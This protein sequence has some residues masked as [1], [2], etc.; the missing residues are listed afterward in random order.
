MLSKLSKLSFIG[1]L[2]ASLT[3]AFVSAKVLAEAIEQPNI[4]IFY[5]DDL[6]WQDSQLN[7][8][9]KPTP[10]E[11]PNMLAL[12]QKGMNF[13]QGYSPAPTCAPS[14]AGI[15]SG[16]HP[17]KL[18]LTH[19]LG[20]GIP[21]ASKN[22]QMIAPYFNDHF[23]PDTLTLAQALKGN[24]YKTGHVG[25]W[26]L[27][28]YAD[29]GPLTVGFDYSYGGRGSHRNS[30]YRSKDFAT[31]AAKDK[32]R[33]SDEKYLPFSE[34]HPEGISYPYDLVTEN[35]L[36]F[37]D[38]NK[39]QPFFLYLAHWMVHYP[40]VTKNRN[41]LEYYTDKLGIEFPKDSSNVTTPG[42]TN[43]YYGAMVTTVDWSLGRLVSLLE[44]TDDPRHPGKKLIDTTY[45]FFTSDNGGAEDRGTEIFTD[46]APLDMGKKHAQE[47]GIRVPMVITGPIVNENA[48]NHQLI[49]QLDFY[50]TILSLTNSTIS[51]ADANKLSGLDITQVIS[52]EKAQA[53]DSNGKARKNLF[54]HFPHNSD[55]DMQSA[56]REGDFKLYKNHK[57]GSYELYRL[58]LNGKRADLEEQF[59]LAKNADF[60]DK[61]GELALNLESHLIENNAEYPHF[62]PHF[63]NEN[64]GDLPG[65]SDT[66]EILASTFDATKR[67]AQ[68]KL[69]K[70]KTPIAQVYALGQIVEPK[71]SENSDKPGKKMTTY[72]KLSAQISKD[73]LSV[74]AKIPKQFSKYLFVAID[75]NNFLVK[76]KINEAN[77]LIGT[78]EK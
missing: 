52:G 14:R 31:R 30:K 64:K 3:S 73:G 29:V 55:D 70:G 72:K 35:A 18:K 15:L 68:I 60:T 33:L 56:L 19:V 46:N 22:S 21:K 48:T 8:I 61:M 59:D 27:G 23:Q 25:K 28:H 9:D 54:W 38:D 2:M 40:T 4:I 36:S 13:T 75:K 26:H 20:A 65:K 32:Y 43:P 45:I 77:D 63:D 42:Q 49:N 53:I 67:V 62:N 5:V 39:T 50:P 57:D 71:L 69:A 44:N 17:A 7:D 16:Q 41:L 47:G 34:K 11:T 76:S 51:K 78:R 1:L 24:G 12:A 6:G 37:V 74:S 58:Y 66:A 10:W